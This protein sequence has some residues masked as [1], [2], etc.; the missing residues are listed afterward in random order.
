MNP[1][2]YMYWLLEYLCMRLF[3]LAAQALPL[4]AA[5]RFGEV[6]GR[7]TAFA[8]PR[9]RRI[10]VGNLLHAY[11]EM[12]KAAAKRMVV[13]VYEHF[14]RF[15]VEMAF[16]PRLLRP[17]NFRKHVTIRHE[18]RLREVL[19]GGKGGIFVT[20]HLGVWEIFGFALR[21]LGATCHSVYRPVK[22]PLID[23]YIR[24][25]RAFFGQVLVKRRGA[26]RTLLRAVRKKG[27]AAILVDQHARR[28][29]IWVPFFGRLAATT[30]APAL[31][32]L[33][34]GAPI[35]LGYSRRLP[36]TY[37]FEVFC[38]VPWT[39]E[40][41]DNRAAD[42]ERIT[43]N[44][45]RRIESYVREVPEQW[46]WLHRRWHEPPSAALEKWR[47]HVGSFRSP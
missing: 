11:P 14:W 8:T 4:P 39:V 40:P 18:D 23:R 3:L 37:K 5:L 31:L 36:G 17:S 13:K 41:T 20:A 19:S 38:D 7:L 32:A 28:D 24:R 16:A 12:S 30:P 22:N 21:H 10:A 35:L 25:Q 34:T 2:R 42:L 45:S 9:R 15:P 43:L 33:R 47:T 26:L 29:G 1:F 46:L 6:V 27:Y 44:I